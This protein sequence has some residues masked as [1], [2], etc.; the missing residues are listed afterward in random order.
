MSRAFHKI[1]RHYPP[2]TCSP[3]QVQKNIETHSWDT[4]DF[5]DCAEYDPSWSPVVWCTKCGWLRY[6]NSGLYDSA[7]SRWPCGE[8]PDSI[9]FDEYLKS[10]SR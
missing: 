7:Q 6:T 3:E 9:S 2:P 8:C 4:H 5:T 10:E 1:A